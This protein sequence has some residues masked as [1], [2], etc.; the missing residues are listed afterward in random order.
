MLPHSR[1]ADLREVGA[2]EHHLFKQ[3]LSEYSFPAIEQLSGAF[4]G[5]WQFAHVPCWCCTVGLAVPRSR[6]VSTIIQAFVCTACLV[7]RQEGQINGQLSWS[8]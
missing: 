5:N 2:G 1:F 4:T 8:K 6:Q 7:N 3:S